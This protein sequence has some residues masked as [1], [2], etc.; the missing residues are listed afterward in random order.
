MAMNASRNISTPPTTGSTIGI[1][2]TTLPRV[3]GLGVVGGFGAGLVGAGHG[4]LW[5]GRLPPFYKSSA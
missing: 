4:F 1:T 3:V 2:G 5:D